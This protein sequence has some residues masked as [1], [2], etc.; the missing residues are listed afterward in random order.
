MTQGRFNCV[1]ATILFNCLAERFGLRVYG[2]ES[3][4]HARSRLAYDGNRVDIETTCPRWFQVL[5]DPQRRLVPNL[6]APPVKTAENSG[7]ATGKLASATSAGTAS[8]AS[9]CREVSGVQLAAMIYYNRGVDLLA[10][11]R[12]GEA[13]AAN[14]KALRLDAESQ[15]ARGNLLATLNNW[16]IALGAEGRYGEAVKRLDQGLDIE[17]SHETLKANYVQV[18]YHWSEG[19]CRAG[20]YAEALA[21][22]E[23]A[24]RRQPGEPYFSQ[25]ALEVHR[26]WAG[27]GGSRD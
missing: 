17:P 8:P 21:V 25:A 4:S 6:D 2:L 3:P 7:P 10:A 23:R 26:R 9:G 1:S 19:L 15:T 20:R 27:P 18:H 22:L 13:L 5:D 24:A 14:A 12:F 16:A 11:G